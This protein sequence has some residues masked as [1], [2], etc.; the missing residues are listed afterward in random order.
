[1]SLLYFR[2]SSRTSTPSNSLALRWYN[3]V[4]WWHLACLLASRCSAIKRKPPASFV[5]SY[6]S[7]NVVVVVPLALPLKAATIFFWYNPFRSRTSSDSS[8]T[9][10]H[11]TPV[12]RLETPYS[13]KARTYRQRWEC[14]LTWARLSSLVP[15]S[16]LL[17]SL[18]SLRG[19][20]PGKDVVRCSS[21][22]KPFRSR[23]PFPECIPFQDA[24]TASVSCTTPDIQ[25]AVFE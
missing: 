4:H 6:P 1:M 25:R 19:P 21:I 14:V 3:S 13:W 16:S 7:A 20:S 12:R 9:A 24:P 11:R 23:F 22:K 10:R 15:S 8:T 18:S 17:R 5:P 2:S